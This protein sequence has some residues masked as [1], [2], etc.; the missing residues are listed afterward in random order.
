MGQL[1]YAFMTFST[2]DMGL[3][4]I[5]DTAATYGYQGVEIRIQSHQAH[6]VGTDMTR[7]ERLRVRELFRERGLSL[8][9]LATGLKIADFDNRD[10]TVAEAGEIIDLASDLGTDR[11]RLFGGGETDLDRAA[12]TLGPILDR[13]ESRGVI[14][15]LETHDSWSDPKTVKALLERV[16]RPC[17]RANWDVLHPVRKG[18]ATIQE[19]FDLL[20][21]WIE[22]VHIHDADFDVDADSFSFKPMGEGSIDHKRVVACLKRMNYTGFISG[23]WIN[24][25]PPRVHLPREIKKLREYEGL[26]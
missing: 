4:E 1:K 9:A 17:L 23:E 11:I 21:P 5:L 16:N 13:G 26:T 8:C 22:H 7:E 12:E 2:P 19:S 10:K 14:I 15:C 18:Y 20:E 6:R 3:E 24:F 25:E